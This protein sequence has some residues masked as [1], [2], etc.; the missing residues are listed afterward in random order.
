MFV[1]NT[2]QLQ[3]RFSTEGGEGGGGGNSHKGGQI[4]IK[5]GL[6]GFEKKV[7]LKRCLVQI[8]TILL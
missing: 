6:S 8:K 3:S 7:K 4:Q 1:T 2:L 5:E